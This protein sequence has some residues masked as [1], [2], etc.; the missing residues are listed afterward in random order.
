MGYE[1]LV[2]KTLLDALLGALK[3]DFAC[4]IINEGPRNETFELVRSSLE[5]TTAEVKSSINRMLS[6]GTDEFPD[7]VT[8]AGI[9]IALH[10]ISVGEGD[11]SGKLIVGSR[12]Q[13]FP[14][15]GERWILSQA[16]LQAMLGPEHGRA[17][18]GGHEGSKSGNATDLTEVVD[19]IPGLAWSAAPDGS[20]EYFNGHYLNYVGLNEDQ[21]R[22]IGWTVAVHPDDI[23]GLAAEWRQMLS[24]RRGGEAEA[25]LRR[26]DGE[27]RWFLFRTNPLLDRSGAVVRWYGLNI[28]IEDRKRAADALEASEFHLRQLTETIPQALWS[29]TPDGAIGYLNKRGLKFLGVEAD[30]LTDGTWWTD[31]LHPDQVEATIRTWQHSV[32]TGEPYQV[33]VLNRHPSEEDYR[34]VDVRAL[35]MR[36]DSG[37]ILMWYGSLIDI[38][39]RKMAQE[40]MA[41]SERRLQLIIDTIPGM[42]WSALPD[43]GGD[44]ANLH[45]RTYLGMGMDEAK[46]WGW[47]S[48]VHP[49]DLPELMEAWRVMAELTQPG[50]CEARLRRFD[51]EYRWFLCRGNPL[52]D[53][54]GDVKWFGI[55]V[56]IHDWKL[57]QDDLREAQAE[58][59]H[60]T[61]VMGMG[62]LTAAIAHELSQPLS[63]I[64]TNASAGLR[65]LSVEPPNVEGAQETVRRTIRDANR[66][67]DVAERLRALYSKRDPM[68][69]VVDLNAIAQEVIGFAHG[70]LRKNG[71]SVR[72]SLAT[73]L[74]AV[75][76][77]RIQL[78]QVIFNFI[79]NST[80]AMY[81]VVGRSKDLEISTM[82]EE[83]GH[84]RLAVKD[85]GV[86]FDPLISEKL[87]SPFFTTKANGMGV[88]LSVSRA[89][90]E[91]HNGRL[92][93]EP[94]NAYGAT[95]AFS[96]PAGRAV[97]VSSEHHFR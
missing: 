22:G 34:W 95:F 65:L 85:A 51:G 57:A 93:A 2:L 46:D 82:Q 48:A 79:K 36:A 94:N 27:Y 52:V 60:M 75:R 59:S 25:R 30:E 56:D 70:D 35:P 47:A 72:T 49:D 17:E 39:D 61:R 53:G 11:T 73:D 7:T 54:S 28:D 90:V 33:E 19:S 69:E 18:S 14:L 83:T 96:I 37:E 81:G 77:D 38:H 97:S 71:V 32:A 67:S 10:V 3:V 23:D 43:G 84:V 40:N 9:M 12:R 86:G 76:G 55:N 62:Q 20:A 13:G 87:F 78:Q 68:V 58:L 91:S 1:I 92:W 21:L 5:F 8:I 29:A 44:F 66:A 45:F 6:S 89:I 31:G 24:L 41:A 26:F 4:I 42:V 80:E 74:P 15:D 50:E 63:G 88:G 64:V 16:V